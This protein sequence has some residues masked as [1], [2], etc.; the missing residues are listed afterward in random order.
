MQL[1][2]N[3]AHLHVSTRTST[4]LAARLKIR[5]YEDVALLLRFHAGDY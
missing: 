1:R 5:Y 2:R 4:S 3:P